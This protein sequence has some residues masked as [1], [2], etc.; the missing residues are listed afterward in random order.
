MKLNIQTIFGIIIIALMIFYFSLNNSN[1]NYVNKN[2]LNTK[3]VR[4]NPNDQIIEPVK[5]DLTNE[6]DMLSNYPNE[7][8][9]ETSMYM[10]YKAIVNPIET[11]YG[12]ISG[13]SY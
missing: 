9:K 4:F 1:D 3:R 2:N 7:N 5:Y 13:N 12:S 6:Y 11:F 8:E 10:N